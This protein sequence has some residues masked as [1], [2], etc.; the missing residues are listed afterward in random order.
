MT[1]DSTG[2]GINRVNKDFLLPLHLALQAGN[3]ELAH[4][5]ITLGSKIDLPDKLGYPIHY[6][7]KQKQL[8]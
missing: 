2:V 5:F 1:E 3:Y 6:A 8:K 7:M 4:K